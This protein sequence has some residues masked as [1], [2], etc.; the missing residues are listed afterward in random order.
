[1]TSSSDSSW[2]F[3]FVAV[4][5]PVQ[6][7]VIAGS[8]ATGS[9]L[10]GEYE[11]EIGQGWVNYTALPKQPLLLTMLGDMAVVLYGTML[12]VRAQ[13]RQIAMFCRPLLS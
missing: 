4:V 8:W 5:A 12:S 13:E 9:D 6:S 1:M 10:N 2:L 3:T 7:D 11:K